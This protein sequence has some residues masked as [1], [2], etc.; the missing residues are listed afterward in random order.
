MNDNRRVYL[1]HPADIPID[2][3]LA[4]VVADQHEYITDISTGGLSFKAAKCLAI[5]A[6]VRIRIPLTNPAFE[7]SARVAWCSPAEGHFLVGVAFLHADEGFRA[8]MVEQVC[9]IEAYKR[10]VR[11]REGRELTG[12]QAA[13]EWIGRHAA[14]FPRF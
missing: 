7:V 9:Q 5:G 11:E 10:E 2:Y 8:R 4:G 14:D 1:R 13:L 3:E 6:I 12:Q